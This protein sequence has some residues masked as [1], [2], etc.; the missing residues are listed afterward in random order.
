M[1]FIH[2]KNHQR[3]FL[4]VGKYISQ[5]LNLLILYSRKSLVIRTLFGLFSPF[6]LA[7]FMFS[8]EKMQG[9]RKTQ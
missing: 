7:F 2:W 5:L 9:K 6:S 3:F 4:M 8:V 1:I